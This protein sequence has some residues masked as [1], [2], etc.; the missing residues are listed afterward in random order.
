MKT[1]IRV[2]KSILSFYFLLGLYPFTSNSME[3]LHS[4][5]IIIINEKL[6]CGNSMTMNRKV[7]R[8]LQDTLHIR[9]KLF[10]EHIKK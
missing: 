5:I 10:S 7:H 4:N 1:S 8:R 6:C 9:S 3:T 2:V